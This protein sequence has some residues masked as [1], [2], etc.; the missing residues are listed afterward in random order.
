MV[1]VVTADDFARRQQEAATK[2]KRAFGMGGGI[3][4]RPLLSIERKERT[5]A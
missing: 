2:A 5:T 4:L 1:T 3:R